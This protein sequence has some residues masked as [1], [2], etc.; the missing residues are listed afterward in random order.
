MV[1]Q[2][3][4][5]ECLLDPTVTEV[6]AIGRTSVPQQS[7][8]LRQL[9]VPDLGDLS[10]HESELSGYDACLFCAGISS[11][12]MS[13]EKYT[14]I[15]YDLA[16]SFAGTLV[17]INPAMTFIYVSGAGTEL[18]RK[19]QHH[20]GSRQRPNRKRSSASRLCQSLHVPSRLHSASTRR[21]LKDSLLSAHL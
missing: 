6:L 7:P 19:R 13:E 1:G 3:A 4:L 11:V 18:D 9:I 8:K 15:T 5:R 16:L 14:K 12:G 10:G 20:V 17:R 2:G 21:P